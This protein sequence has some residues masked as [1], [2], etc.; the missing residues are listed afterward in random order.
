MKLFFTLLIVSCSTIVL[1]LIPKFSGEINLAIHTNQFIN[2]LLKYQ[3]IALP[4][5]LLVA[6]FVW[7]LEPSS[8]HYFAKGN[9]N[10]LAQ[11]EM[12]LGISGKSTWRTNGLQLLLFISIPTA[13]FM[14][15]ALSST[16]SF[17]NWQWSFIPFILLLSL[18]NSFVEEI[19]FRFAIVGGLANSYNK[20]IVLILSAVAFGLPHYFGW[21]SGAIGVIMAGVLG[22]VLA[23]AS[24]ETKGLA[25]AWLIHFVQDVIIFSAV[26]MMNV[27]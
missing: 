13:I 14:F 17:N 5:A 25:I 8:K 4:I 2:S 20:T 9:L 26:F 18:S 11:K 3:L 21:P 16:N 10:T 24:I 23:K 12:W 15:L 19:I 7:K 6:L 27:K 1:L 22:Y